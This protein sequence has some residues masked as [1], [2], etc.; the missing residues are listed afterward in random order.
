MTA[1]STAT[2]SKLARLTTER[3]ALEAQVTS[4]KRSLE[5]AQDETT[6][7]RT[8][9]TNWQKLKKG[10]DADADDV[11]KKKLELEQELGE[12]RRRISE[13]E[14]RS[15]ETDVLEAKLQ[16]QK[17]RIEKLKHVL[18]EWKVEHCV[19]GPQTSFE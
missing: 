3:D 16:K 17:D 14:T 9:L 2:S 6:Q 8:Q 15:G 11:R 7:L 18:E 19:C 10:E 5:L 1:T 13:F 4:L 12:A